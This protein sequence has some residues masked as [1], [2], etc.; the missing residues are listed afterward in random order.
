[1]FKQT[2]LQLTESRFARDERGFL[3]SSELVVIATILVLGMIVGLVELQGALISELNDVGESIGSLNQS[4][5]FPGTN[6]FKGGHFV[7][8]F[9]SAFYDGSDGCDCNQGAALYCSPAVIGEGKRSVGTVVGEAVPPAPAPV[10]V[11]PPRVIAAPPAPVIHSAPVVCPPELVP[12]AGPVP[13]IPCPQPCLGEVV[14]PSAPV[15]SAPVL[16]KVVPHVV[17]HT[18]PAPTPAHGFR[19]VVVPAPPAPAK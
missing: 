5:S 6:T 11:A 19:P 8:T 7:G 13:S 14:V 10:M 15:Y 18:A 4:Y 16:P 12:Q 9:G 1:M 3:V 17:P 2:L